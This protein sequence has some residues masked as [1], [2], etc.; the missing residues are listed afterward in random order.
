MALRR[1]TAGFS[2]GLAFRCNWTQTGLVVAPLPL[3]VQHFLFIFTDN[4]C[5]L[6][7]H[8]SCVCVC[9]CHLVCVCVLF[10]NRFEEL[11]KGLHR[12]WDLMVPKSPSVYIALSLWAS[13]GWWTRSTASSY[14]PRLQPSSRPRDID[15]CT[16]RKDGSDRGPLITELSVVKP[17]AS[18]NELLIGSSSKHENCH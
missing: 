8:Y 13:R 11:P 6:K 10:P 1:S 4:R 2:S 5:F 3:L 12:K 15:F 7:C 17:T 16:M 18:F 14:G 9:V